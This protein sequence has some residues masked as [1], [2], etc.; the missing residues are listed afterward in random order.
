[1]YLK[2]F[3]RKELLERG[4]EAFLS[5][6]ESDD[7]KA[8]EGRRS[9]TFVEEQNQIKESFKKAIQNN[10]DDEDAD[11]LKVREKTSEEKMKE[12]REYVEW[13]KG[14][15]SQTS[16]KSAMGMQALRHYWMDPNLDEGEQFLRDYILDRNYLEKDSERIPTYDEIVGFDDD[17]DETEVE[18]QE[19]FER[20]FNFR[21]EEPDSEFVKTYPRTI[22]GS[23]R[24]TD[25][26]RREKRKQRETKKEKEKEQK[27][28]EI[29]RLK[30]LKRKEIM[31]KLEKLKEITGNPNVGF[32]E[33]DIEGD[34]DPKKYDEV[35]QRAFNAEFY[36]ED[37]NEKPVFEDDLDDI[38]NWDEWEG[39][40]DENVD[41]EQQEDGMFEPHSEDPNFNMD[42]D[43]QENGNDPNEFSGRKRK[44][45]SRFGRVVAQKKPVF[46][47]DEKTFEEYFDEYYKLDYEDIIGDMPCRFQYR[48]VVPN[49]FGLTTEE[50]LSC[51]DRELNQWVSVKKMSQYRPE[52]EEYYEVKKFRKRGRDLQKKKR[53]L[54][55]LAETESPNEVNDEKKKS[56][57]Q[58]LP[59]KSKT[60]KHSVDTKGAQNEQTEI[61][62][63]TKNSSDKIENTSE[64]E[65]KDLPG[66][67]ISQA[68][69]GESNGRN[70]GESKKTKKQK[71]RNPKGRR[72]TFEELKE[73]AVKKRLRRQFKG[74]KQDKLSKLSAARLASYG[75]TRKKKKK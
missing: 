45:R 4:S 48:Q 22:Q 19:E 68:T 2:D 24:K 39:N 61:R 43:Y 59:K 6:E 57:D 44:G 60:L 3:E 52:N 35:M 74:A 75:L 67:E 16:T 14:Q 56:L 51:P 29:K 72:M 8:L 70:E 31:E 46:N 26:R 23:V 15:E 66:E 28:E 40:Y 63:R 47:P 1:M 62:K 42:A 71:M 73:L 20:K 7:E 30:N 37:E 17:E 32:K 55:S 11:F 25:E 18:K 65:S 58:S 50:I 69:Q 54:I 12:E 10:D 41:D 9:P 64:K 53:I 36:E 38:E 49:D 27:R 33:E 5:D 13:L 21:F 34:F